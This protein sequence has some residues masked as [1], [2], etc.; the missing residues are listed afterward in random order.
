MK[1]LNAYHIVSECSISQIVSQVQLQLLLTFNAELE[2]STN[3]AISHVWRLGEEKECNTIPQDWDPPMMVSLDLRGVCQG[4]A[5][6][7]FGGWIQLP[8]IY[9]Q[10]P[11]PSI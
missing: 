8:T 2:D 6:L 1:T 4:C 3:Q 7:Q 10:L 9:T 11:F 5:N